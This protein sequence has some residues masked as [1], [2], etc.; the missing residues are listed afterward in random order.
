MLRWVGMPT[1]EVQ[2]HELKGSLKVEIG[3]SVA[4]IK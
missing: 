3:T 1:Y 4:L 2:Q